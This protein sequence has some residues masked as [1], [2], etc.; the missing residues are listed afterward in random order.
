MAIDDAVIH[1][2]CFCDILR[3]TLLMFAG[4]KLSA[5]VLSPLTRGTAPHAAARVSSRIN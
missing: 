3:G 2:A 1:L 5:V 4:G